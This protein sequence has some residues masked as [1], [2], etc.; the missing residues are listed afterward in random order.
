MGLS[1]NLHKVILNSEEFCS[2][3]FLF[4]SLVFI[5]IFYLKYMLWVCCIIS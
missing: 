5:E 3:F 1:F 4:V 2:Y